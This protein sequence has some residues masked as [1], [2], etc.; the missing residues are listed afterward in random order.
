M[1]HW[2]GKGWTAQQGC[3]E[4]TECRRG[5]PGGPFTPLPTWH[6][7]SLVKLLAWGLQ[8]WGGCEPGRSPASQTQT[9]LTLLPRPQPHPPQDCLLAPRDQEDTLLTF[10][11]LLATPGPDLP[12]GS[13]QNQQVSGV[14]SSRCSPCLVSPPP[15]SL[16]PDFPF[17]T[18][19]LGL[20]VL[21]CSINFPNHKCST[22]KL[23]LEHERPKLKQYGTTRMVYTGAQ[24]A[25]MLAVTLGK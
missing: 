21:Y 5:S 18:Y 25:S 14:V 20:Q 6:S 4:G 7:E 24:G 23:L 9:P 10:P 12:Q 1:S 13:P 16:C 22:E 19:N 11:V 15:I 8:S 3:Y 17:Y 2:P